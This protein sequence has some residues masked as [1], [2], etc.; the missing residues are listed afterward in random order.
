MRSA[1]CRVLPSEG[2]GL[3]VVAQPGAFATVYH[4]EH[5]RSDIQKQEEQDR[6]REQKLVVIREG[7]F[8]P[9][10]EKAELA[11]IGWAV[12]SPI[13]VAFMQKH[14]KPDDFSH[15]ALRA[16]AERCFAKYEADKPITALTL[17]MSLKTNTDVM[18]IAG[19]VDGI[20][21]W[22]LDISFAAPAW[23]SD[24]DLEAQVTDV[25]RK[26]AELHLRNY[27]IEGIVDTIE[28]LRAGDE[29]SAALAPIVSVADLENA[30]EDEQQGSEFGY[31]AADDLIREIEADEQNGGRPGANTGIQ[32]L[33]EI[34]GGI[35]PSNLVFVGGR[36]AM[37]KSIVGTT[38]AKSAAD[39]ML[40]SAVFCVDYFS[41]EMTKS[42]L[43]GRILCDIDYDTAMREGWQPIHYSRVQM[44]RLSDHER[45]RLVHARNIMA[46]RY[47]DI[48]IHDRDELSMASIASL[49]RA[50]AARTKKKQL[51]IIDHMHLIEPSSRY[52]GRKVDEISEITKGAKRLA[53]RL[54]AG[55]VLLAQLSRDLEKREEKA[56]Q[57]SDFRDSGSIEQDGDVLI[58]INRPHY[59]LQ[60]HKP[61]EGDKIVAWEGEL[62]RTQNLIELGVLKNRH[63]KTET[64]PAFIDIASAVIRDEK[65][66]YGRVPVPQEEMRF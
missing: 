53:K 31:Y 5:M 30:R 2:A 55:V 18:E 27:A 32:G 36:P 48:E 24:K 15:P 34:I 14:V 9:W 52:A 12:K 60:R 25:A 16:I 65:P 54:D 10:D 42:E 1:A 21:P 7:D 11:L 49:A 64:V 3:S 61:K 40:S 23:G 38:F 59:F 66:I 6:L 28:R 20:Q 37:G 35:Y 44:R 47:P 57:L 26:V 41:L 45:E 46:E 29:L 19:S 4:R 8:L 33:Q 39:L 63:G 62:E 50:K 17:A 13:A 43:I 51:I 58:G 56:P 22:L